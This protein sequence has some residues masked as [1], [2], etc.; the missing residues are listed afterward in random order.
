MATTGEEDEFVFKKLIANVVDKQE[1]GIVY[2]SLANDGWVEI[3]DFWC[4]QEV[5]FEDLRYKEGKGNLCLL[6]DG[7]KKRIKMVQGLVW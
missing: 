2:L 1:N 3:Y 7:C 4:M 5:D 6:P